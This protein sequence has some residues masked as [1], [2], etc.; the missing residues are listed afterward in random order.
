MPRDGSG[1]YAVP[2]GTDG[3]PDTTI[4]SAR[5][6]LFTADLEQVLNTPS[7]IISGGTGGS[8]PDAALKNI[9]G[10]KAGQVVTNFNQYDM[11][12]RLVLG[13][14]NRHGR[15]DS[16]PRTFSGIAYVTDVNNMFIEARDTRTARHAAGAKIYPAKEGRRLGPVD[17]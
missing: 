6:N 4:D 12:L 14:A 7:P 5:Y 17:G 8:S 13:G 1:F 9:G 3:A 11:A 16:G 10:E 2:P 15:P